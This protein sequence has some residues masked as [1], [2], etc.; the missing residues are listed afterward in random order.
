MKDV[1]V[2]ERDKYCK[3]IPEITVRAVYHLPKIIFRIVAQ[4]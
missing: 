2:N 3:K 1:L 4:R